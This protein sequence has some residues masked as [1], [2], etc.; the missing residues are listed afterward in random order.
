M[1]QSGLG[2]EAR[3]LLRKAR[4][5][6]FFFVNRSHGIR[7]V[8]LSLEVYTVAQLVEIKRHALELRI[9]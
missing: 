7:P 3:E 8:A 6:V 4:F 5:S 9:G 1:I 2:I